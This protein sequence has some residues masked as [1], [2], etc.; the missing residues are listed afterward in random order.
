MKGVALR[1]PQEW[2]AFRIPHYGLDHQ[3][4]AIVD[5]SVDFDFKKDL[6]LLDP[7][8]YPEFVSVVNFI[9]N[10]LVNYSNETDFWEI[11]NRNLVTALLTQT[12][13]TT[14]GVEYQLDKLVDALTVD[15]QVE[16]GSSL[17]NYNRASEVKGMPDSSGIEFDESFRFEISDYGLDHQG[18]A[19]V[20]IDVDLDFKEDIGVEDPY[21][22]PEFVSIVNFIKNYLITYTNETDFWEILNRNLVTALLTQKI[23]TPFGVEYQLDQVVDSLSVDIAVESGSSLVN[24]NRASEVKGSPAGSGIQFDEAFH[25]EISDYGLDHQGGAIVDIQVDLDFK[26][27]IGVGNPYAYPEFVSIVNFIKGY[28]VN[29]TNETDFWEVLNKN[30]VTAL[31]T[32]KIPTTFGVEY[33]LDKLVDAL[34]VDI[35]VEAGSSLVNYN[36]ASKV[37]GSPLAAGIDFDEEFS[38]AITNYGLDHQGGAIVDILVDMDFKEGIGS[39]SPFDYPEFVSIVNFIKG[40]LTSYPN[41]DDFWEILNKNLAEALMTQTIPTTFGVEYHLADVVDTLTVDIQVQPGSSLVNFPRTST[42]AQ[43][44]AIDAELINTGEDVFTLSA[45]AAGG[46][47]L[48]IRNAETQ[49]SS[50]K[51]LAVFTVDDALGRI[52]DLAPGDAG[53]LQAALARTRNGLSPLANLPA[54]FDPAS[55]ARSLSFEAG[56][57]LAFM[58]I[59]ND[60]LDQIRQNNGA[61]ASVLF[62]SPENLTIASTGRGAYSLAWSDGNGGGSEE[63]V[64]NIEATLAPIPLGSAVQA[65]QEAEVLDLR[66]VDQAR[67]VQARF[68]L[69]REAA[70]DNYVGFY[71]IQDR[72]GT[73]TDSVTGATL[74]PGD[75]NYAAVAV[76][77]RLP[78]LDLR[79]ANH[80]TV[81]FD[82]ILEAGSLLAPFVVVQGGPEL[83]FDAAQVKDPAVYF[84]FIAAN[85]DG[86]DHIRLLGNNAFGF[87]DLE[88]GGD[89]DFNDMILEVSLA[90][91]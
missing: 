32:Q 70:F 91:I 22:Y 3:G 16:A 13:P 76:R 58:L 37:K 42:V 57:K 73:I 44:L 62:G 90:V 35:Q 25:F 1:S 21:A 31:L 5:I 87:E 27:D 69:Y 20:D 78:G 54:G 45:P 11:L 23:P 47:R 49:A 15:I 17:V 2:F 38:F 4:G 41:E 48:Q 19:I 60:T 84:P 52:D 53:Y 89:G 12:I 75:S 55:L 59:Q 29:Y 51:D 43:S 63:V 88:Y 18:G 82:A 9:K 39:L 65:E 80:A 86:V 6:G 46:A 85:R 66:E 30:L 10:Y 8:A 56:E 74:R 61:D 81:R 34:T 50:V 24:F 68:D 71:A 33:Q 40:Y 72:E 64:F 28:L 7:Y 14:F 36:R 77:D 26:Q 83:L 79:V 67:T